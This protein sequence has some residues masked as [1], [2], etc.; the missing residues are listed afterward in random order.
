MLTSQSLHVSVESDFVQ[1]VSF[2]GSVLVYLIAVLRPR[3]S[4]YD[5]LSGRLCDDPPRYV[6]AMERVRM[7]TQK[8]DSDRRKIQDVIAADAKVCP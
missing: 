3:S 6:N 4:C 5:F 7:D 2:L 8:T 1:S